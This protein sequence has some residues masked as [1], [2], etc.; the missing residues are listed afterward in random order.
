MPFVP[1]GSI[2]LPDLVEKAVAELHGQDAIEA[3]EG[4][5]HS[6]KETTFI[7]EDG[8]SRRQRAM[9]VVR[10]GKKISFTKDSKRW[11]GA[12]DKIQVAL[13]EGELTAH[14]STGVGMEYA[15]SKEY[16]R[17]EDAWLVFETGNLENPPEKLSELDGRPVYLDQQAAMDWLAAL[18]GTVAP[19]VPRQ[20]PPPP[21]P[22]KRRRRYKR[23]DWPN[24]FSQFDEM[25]AEEGMPGPDIPS[26]Q[27]HAD[28][29]RKLIEWYGEKYGASA[30][31]DEDY[32]AKN[33]TRKWRDLKANC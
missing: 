27:T 1:K 23:Y 17:G 16:W 32:L 30:A 14:T 5:G 31:P 22:K 8:G 33:L 15:I 20:A 3:Y 4:M 21:K 28:V 7:D 9:H 18:P 25:I 11:D 12:K 10:G 24:I 13:V 19:S 26:W 2:G 6:G 29:H